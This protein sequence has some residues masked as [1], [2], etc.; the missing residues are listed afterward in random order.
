MVP[1]ARAPQDP[2]QP[3]N[4]SGVTEQ[5]NQASWITGLAP[6]GHRRGKEAAFWWQEYP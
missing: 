3:A 1:V 4:A 5:R 6:V 2:H